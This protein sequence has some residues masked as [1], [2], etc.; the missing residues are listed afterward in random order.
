VAA[1]V[2]VQ[3]L[4]R[5]AD[6]VEQREPRLARHELVVPLQVELDRDGAPAGLKRQ[7]LVAHEPEYGGG[8]PRLGR[9]K[10]QADRGAERHAPV[11]DGPWTDPVK[12]GE[13]ADG[14]L[15]LGYGERRCH[16][17]APGEHVAE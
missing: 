14:G 11:P 9:D 17:P 16:D 13:R 2:G 7:R 3:R 8:D 4:V 12:L 1:R 15:P 6:G 5:R 10:R